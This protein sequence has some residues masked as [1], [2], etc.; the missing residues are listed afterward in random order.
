M[1]KC[2]FVCTQFNGFNYWYLTQIILFQYKSFVCT[3]LNS[4][5]DFYLTPMMQHMC[6]WWCATTATGQL[7]KAAQDY[8][9]TDHRKYPCTTTGHWWPKSLIYNKALYTMCKTILHSTTVEQ[10]RLSIFGHVRRMPEEI[11]IQ[12][13]LWICCNRVLQMT[14]TKGS[15]L[16]KLAWY[17][18]GRPPK[19]RR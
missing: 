6:L 5:K 11:P 12:K 8:L 7:Q 18:A 13:S 17:A 16:P 4:F 9:D 3:Q 15:P 19:C 1:N 14:I 2:S 10:L